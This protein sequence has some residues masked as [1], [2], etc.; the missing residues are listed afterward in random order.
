MNH[1]HESD[2]GYNDDQGM[3]EIGHDEEM[4]DIPNNVFSVNIND[5]NN[6]DIILP[7]EFSENVLSENVNININFINPN[8]NAQSNPNSN[9]ANNTTTTNSNSNNN[10]S[11]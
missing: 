5:L 1:D 9:N 10:A 7:D 4:S 3:D 8:Q 2:G 6:H 11:N